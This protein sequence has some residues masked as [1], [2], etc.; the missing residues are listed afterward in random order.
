MQEMVVW[1]FSQ[2]SELAW[3]SLGKLPIVFSYEKN[4]IIKFDLRLFTPTAALDFDDLLCLHAAKSQWPY[5][6]LRKTIVDI[7]QLLSNFFNF[8]SFVLLKIFT[9]PIL[10]TMNFINYINN[11]KIIIIVVVVVVG[12]T[13]GAI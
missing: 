2:L 9:V 4:H 13:D 8:L 7:V 1:I 12:Q 11:F 3:N 5:A 6:I 10:F